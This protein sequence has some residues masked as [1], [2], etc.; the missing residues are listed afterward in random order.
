LR[1]ILIKEIMPT[2]TFQSGL[3]QNHRRLT[4]P[5]QIVLEAIN[6]ANRHLTP[7]EI[8]ERARAKYPHL[9]LATVYRSLDLLVKLG[10]VQRIHLDE[11][12]HSYAPVEQAHGH[13]LVCSRCGHT[14]EFA[15]CDLEPLIKALKAKT[16]YQIDV[17]V[18]E[19]MGRCPSCQTK[20]RGKKRSERSAA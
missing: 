10:Y 18:L 16:G 4:R 12:C 8:Y 2:R 20:R 19:L 7:A 3:H 6:S 14:E 15:D 13:H 5:R 17:H 11:G 1:T 9:G